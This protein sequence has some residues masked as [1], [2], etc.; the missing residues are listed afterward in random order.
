MNGIRHQESPSP[1]P[2]G[3]GFE[4]KVFLCII[5]FKALLYNGLMSTIILKTKLYIPR[6][7]SKIVLRPRLIE[8]LNRGIHLKSTLISAPAGYGK[9]TLLSEWISNCERPV[10]WLSLDEGHNE[11]TSFLA[12]LIAALQTVE[13]GIG[14]GGLK[15]LHSPQPPST[16]S[17]LTVL[18]NEIEAIPNPFILVLD[19][20]HTIDAK[21][22]DSALTF[23]I[24]HL[25]AKMHLVIAT[26]EDPHLPLARYRTRGELTELRAA[27][28]RF[29]TDEVADFFNC[30]MDLNLSTDEITALESRTEGWIAG[31]QLAAISLR[32]HKDTAEF[33][34]SFTGSHHFVM[35]YLVEEVLQQQSKSLQ[36]FLLCTSILDRMCGPLCDAVMGDF[37]T[38]G[39]K[40]LEYLEQANLFIIPMDNERRWYRYH[41]LFA[42]LLRQRFQ[43]KTASSSGGKGK[44]LSQWHIR[45]SQWFEDNGLEVEAF[46]YAAAANDIERC[47]RLMG[48]GTMP[49]HFRGVAVQILNWLASLPKE[50]FNAR[51]SLMVIYPSLLLA[52]G[53]TIGVEEKLKAAETVLQNVEMDDKIRDLFGKIAMARATLGL[54]R[55]DVETML[56]QSRRALEFLD[57]KNLAS[58]ANALW[59][60]GF[61]YFLRKDYKAARSA[62]T[63]AISLSQQSGD[64]FRVILA[65]I[66][67]GMVQESENQLYQAVETYR[68]VLQLSG[69]QPTT[70]V[71]QAHLGL[72][73]AFYQWNDLDAA[74]RHGKMSLDLASQ[75]ESHIDRH[76][77]CEVFLARLNLARGDADAA[78]AILDQ[79]SQSARRNN[80]VQ[81]IPQVVSA[82]VV[83]LLR[84]GKWK[85]AANL[86]QTHDLPLCRARVLLAQGDTSAAL[87]LLHPP[88][89]KMAAKSS[90]RE[91]LQGLVLQALA[92]HIHGEK[93]NAQQVLRRALEM[94]QPGGF[95]RIFVDEGVPMAKLLSEVASQGVMPEYTNKLLT[96]FA[97]EKRKGK[98]ASSARPFHDPLSRRELEI[99]QL[100]AEGLSNRQIGERLYLELT[101]VKGHNQKIFAKLDVKRRTEA[102]ARARQ[103]GLL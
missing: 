94:A 11:V 53:Q 20:F 24:R 71:H 61:A 40:T 23:L 48:K 80:F 42:E 9:T 26:R 33:I 12:Y 87:E 10:A 68:H 70:I 31:L 78:A 41:H 15:A 72:A 49:L 82:Q 74:A 86:A 34:Q 67:M 22:V 50:V 37:S 38:S 21:P 84:Q 93:K 28:L 75:Y 8:R 79:A 36:T 88:G 91:Q 19:D 97:A 95:I 64:I 45:A 96:A 3:P 47:V 43:R 5:N 18:I 59:T 99:L 55:Y 81:C 56:G 52:N 69:D 17:I 100:I 57:S 92:F 2:F 103:L 51:P 29:S 85:T 25:P 58:R 98:V 83:T 76:I 102:V 44:E 65:T 90:P 14:A 32:G 63:E 30:V 1:V 77:L 46:Q 101:T 6:L 4:K 73:N 62:Y 60:L 27:D 35:D 39:Q 16:E 66:G 54:T 7:Q 89:R 13:A